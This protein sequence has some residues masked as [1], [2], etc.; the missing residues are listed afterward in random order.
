[1]NRLYNQTCWQ[2]A[3]QKWFDNC[4]L[5]A[6]DSWKQFSVLVFWLGPRFSEH[7][8]LAKL[9]F[10]Y[11]YT[12]LSRFFFWKCSICRSSRMSGPPKRGSS[13]LGWQWLSSKTWTLSR[14][15]LRRTARFNGVLQIW[16]TILKDLD[17]LNQGAE[18]HLRCVFSW[19]NKRSLEVFEPQDFQKPQI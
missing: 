10:L 19:G 6:I 11:L 1:M 14:T 5:W 8:L 13:L 7:L 18:I 3:V 16:E 2:V 17:L 15:N 9:L 4:M 12:A